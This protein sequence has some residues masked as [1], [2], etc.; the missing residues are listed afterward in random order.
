MTGDRSLPMDAGL[1]DFSGMHRKIAIDCQRIL[2]REASSWS[3]S[4]ENVIDG[5][6][7]GQFSVSADTVRYRC[8]SAPFRDG[9]GGRIPK[10]A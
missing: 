1:A 2:H 6:S 7:H 8:S 3:C 5:S 10:E 9:P 4:A